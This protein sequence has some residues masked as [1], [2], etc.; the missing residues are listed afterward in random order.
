MES[1]QLLREEYSYEVT[2]MCNVLPV[3]LVVYNKFQPY[4]KDTNPRIYLPRN[5]TNNNK[6]GLEKG[7]KAN[8]SEGEISRKAAAKIRKAVRLQILTA[9]KKRVHSKLENKWFDFYVNFVTLTLSSKQIHSDDEIKKHILKPFIRILQDKHGVYK[10]IWK[11]ESQNNGNIHFHITLD[12]F[13]HWRQ[14]R[15]YWN[16]CQDKLCY[17]Q[18]SGISDP[19]STDIHAVKNISKLENYLIK[20]LSKSDDIKPYCSLYTDVFSDHFYNKM[21]FKWISTSKGIFEK[22][23]KIEGKVWDCSSNLKNGSLSVPYDLFYKEFEELKGSEFIDLRD[24]YCQAFPISSDK[25]KQFPR[26]KRLWEDFS[27]H[28]VDDVK[29]Y[30]TVESF[31]EEKITAVKQFE[32]LPF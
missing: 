27:S 17:V 23:R 16:K 1:N 20:Y 19:N 13:V 3:K 30:F 18:R 31:K 21:N 4:L 9:K 24:K 14:V 10:Y 15:K 25:F 32:D 12:K 2:Q 26:L 8:K 7:T 11:A 22:K 5:F 29:T 28:L 6:A